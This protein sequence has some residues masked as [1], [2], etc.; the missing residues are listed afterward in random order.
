MYNFNKIIIAIIIVF[1]FFSCKKIRFKY[2][3]DAKPQITV[4]GGG[5]VTVVLEAGMGNWS[6]FYKNLAP[7]LALKYKVVTINRAGYSNSSVP[8]NTRDAKTIA[9][10]LHT[11]LVQENLISDTIILVGHSFGGSVVRVYQNLYPEKIKGI[12]LLDASHPDQFARLPSQFNQLK[13]DQI[14]GIQKTIKTAEKGLLKTKQGKKK[15]PK[16]NLPADMLDDY[17]A[18][19]TNPQYYATFHKE[20]FSFDASLA[21]MKSLP[22]LDALPLLVLSSEVSMDASTISGA[23]NYPFAEHNQTWLL[24]QN[25]LALLSSNSVHVSTNLSNHYLAVFQS[26]W[27]A[28]NITLFIKSKVQ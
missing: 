21:Q 9:E 15:I 25:E 17:Y 4:A 12:V 28:D 1:L 18:I 16:F 26:Q 19:T 5:N 20:V 13:L 22:S 7:L 2:L 11:F 3:P 8:S 23:K 6:L 24:L 27:V 14:E 10:E